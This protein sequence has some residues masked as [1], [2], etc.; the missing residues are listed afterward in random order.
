MAKLLFI[1]KVFNR[2]KAQTYFRSRPHNRASVSV[3]VPALNES[4]NLPYVL[5]R[6][7]AWVKEIILVNGNSSD[8]TAEVVSNIR[9]GVRIIS[10]LG[11]GKG[12]AL[13]TGFEAA[14]G[15][16]II[17]L[18]ADGSTDPAE[19][20]RFCALL[21]AA[22]FVKG[23]RFMQGG[24]TADMEFHRKFGNWCFKVAV[25]TL[26]GG[27]F[28]DLCYGYMGFWRY[29][30]PQLN[31][32]S[33]GFEVETLISIRALKANLKI[34]EVPSF[35]Y[36]RLHGKSNLRAVP[37]G[38]RVLKTIINERFRRTLPYIVTSEPAFIT[39]VERRSRNRYG[40][41]PYQE[42]EDEVKLLQQAVD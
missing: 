42:A 38:W 11:K 6:I 24:G 21:G 10:Q 26:Y 32:D 30:L 25:R 40:V 2:Q 34:A 7:P 36:R 39:Q 13:K 22:D 8:D 9:P 18:D 17:M 33:D 35:E 4:A 29:I 20:P 19:I 27:T 37:D 14:T 3:I 5:P 15:D 41:S 28:S 23:S 16:I 1:D 31:I 12:A